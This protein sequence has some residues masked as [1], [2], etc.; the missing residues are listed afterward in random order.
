MK[1]LSLFIFLL[2]AICTF[3][4]KAV[5]QIKKESIKTVSKQD[6][7]LI[8]EILD[9]ID[10][11]YR[12]KT[13]HT[14]FEMKIENENWERTLKVEMWTKGLDK[15]LLKI[16]S[17]KKDAGISTLRVDNNMWNY[18]PKINKTIKVPPS[19]MM[20]SWMGSDF[21]NDDL[22]KEST[23]KNDYL[24]EFK[25]YENANKYL[26]VLTPMENTASVWGRVE[27]I[28]DKKTKIIEK[29][30]SYS[31]RGDLSRTT[32]FTNVRS[33]SGKTIPTEMILSSHAKNKSKTTVKYIDAEFD[34][35]IKDSFFSKRNLIKNSK[36]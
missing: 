5:G 2:S 32:E 14:N 13:S 23:F 33:I 7:I 28:I 6:K 36:I 10:K 20:G 12:S 24:A 1:N 11:L 34:K 21:T 3:S 30:F 15:T 31:E 19:M 25:P 9:S 18:F 17:P 29:Q 26:V 27:L 4:N 16:N 35:P 22:V 8:D